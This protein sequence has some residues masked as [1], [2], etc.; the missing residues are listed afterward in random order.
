MYDRP[1]AALW[2]HGR[3]VFAAILRGASA[4]MVILCSKNA[5]FTIS[6]GA[7]GLVLLRDLFQLV[8]K[9]GIWEIRGKLVV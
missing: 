8:A 3:W 9:L 7:R 4:S 5:I 1:P 2:V 6:F